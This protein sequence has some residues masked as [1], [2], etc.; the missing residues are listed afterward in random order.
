M[1]RLPLQFVRCLYCGHIYNQ[2]FEYQQVP[3]VKNPNLM[4]NGSAS[5]Q[6]H[7]NEL[8]H[9]LSTHLP[10]EPTVIEIGCGTGS[11][12]KRLAQVHGS[13]RFIGFDPNATFSEADPHVELHAELFVAAQHLQDYQPDLI[14]SRHVLEH[15]INPLAF[16]QELLVFSALTEV[17]P[18]LFFEVPCVDRLLRY[19][20]VEDLYYEHNSH[21]TQRSFKTLLQRLG[22]EILEMNQSYNQEV[23]CGLIQLLPQAQIKSFLQENEAFQNQVAQAQHNI[24]LEL[25]TLHQNGHALAL[26]GGTGKGAAFVHH[27]GLLPQEI[28]L[29]VVDSDLAKVGTFVPGTHYLIHH[30][31]SLLTQA[32]KVIV[33]PAQWRAADIVLEIASLQIPHS[34]ILIEHQGHL[35]DFSAS[36]HPYRLS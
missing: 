32:P 35:I 34:Q 5:W 2:A 9:R 11:F 22:A 23:L 27:F 16:L 17:Y 20:R 14:L 36:E 15:L 19:G 18:L 33:I 26:W 28:P 10:A 30:P 6:Q 31:E 4:Y 8:A 7:L 29:H 1:V 24:P 3:Y 25:K 12:L 21:F 13:G